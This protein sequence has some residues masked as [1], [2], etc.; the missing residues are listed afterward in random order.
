MANKI[1]K[2]N[3]KNMLTYE[4]FLGITVND[5][6]TIYNKLDKIEKSNDLLIKYKLSTEILNTKI[7]DN[8]IAVKRVTDLI[9]KLQKIVEAYYLILEFNNYWENNKKQETF[10]VADFQIK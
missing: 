6:E 10:K 9:E 7:P 8:V 3:I 1:L 4:Q 5:N 2:G